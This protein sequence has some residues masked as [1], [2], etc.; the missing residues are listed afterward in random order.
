LFWSNVARLFS[1]IRELRDRDARPS[2]AIVFFVLSLFTVFILTLFRFLNPWGDQ[3]MLVTRPSPTDV[4]WNLWD[5]GIVQVVLCAGVVGAIW[6]LGYFSSIVGFTC[7]VGAFAT[8]PNSWKSYETHATFGA[9]I[10]DLNAFVTCSLMG[11]GLV[12]SF[13][14]SIAGIEWQRIQSDALDSANIDSQTVRRCLAW[15]SIASGL[16]GVSIIGLLVLFNFVLVHGNSLDVFSLKWPLAVITFLIVAVLVVME[17][18]FKDV[19]PEWL[20]PTTWMIII[21]AIAA[22]LALFPS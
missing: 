15:L 6:Q 20:S 13:M 1:S 12:A 7:L 8:A 18:R 14:R 19:Y 11:V 22:V 9:W 21:G 2:K 16:L 10:S 17:A 3:T 5:F 4:F